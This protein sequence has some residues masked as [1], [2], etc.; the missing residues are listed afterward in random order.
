MNRN[1]R[2]VL[3]LLVSAWPA[4][5]AAQ[6]TDPES[7][8]SVESDEPLPFRGTSIIYENALSA[9]SFDAGAEQD[10]NPAYVMVWGFRPRY[11]LYET[12]SAR[13]SFDVEL[14][15]TDSDWTQTRYEPTISDTSLGFIYSSFYTIPVVE[16]KLS[17]G[18]T[19]G[20]PTSKLSQAR[21]LY[22]SLSPTFSI[23]RDFDVLGGISLTYS[24]RYTKNFN[25]YPGAVMDDSRYP[26]PSDLA[27]RTQCFNMGV[28]SPSMAFYNTFDLNIYF[29]ERLYF[30]ASVGVVNSLLYPVETATV[31]T[32]GGTYEV[33]E[34]D[35]NTDHRG[36]MTY[37]VEVGYDVLDWMTVALG[38]ST[39]TEQLADDG[40]LRAPFFN[41]FTSMYL[42]L[43]FAID[44]I[45]T[46]IQG[47]G[48]DGDAA[49]AASSADTAVTAARW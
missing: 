48:D 6:V 13:L 21:T 30:A 41:R 24:F 27:D 35:D 25:R 11:Y 18:L 40:S 2:W 15:L 4:A 46:A 8:G 38:A 12:L 33:P 32:L 5:A 34:S 3:L 23:R 22:L 45:V 14:E 47:M 39:V 49:V 43:S 37:M 42:D 1:I 44:G 17:G 36:A 31:D 28:R 9:L 29:T 19:F 26:C 20:F 16:L 10:Y 7:V